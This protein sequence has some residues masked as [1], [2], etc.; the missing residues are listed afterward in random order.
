MKAFLYTKLPGRGWTWTGPSRLWLGEDHVLLVG[1][2]TFYES[3]RRFFFA[4]LQA[5]V[6]QRTHT[7]KIWNGV[8]AS[9]LLFF[10]TL[11]M[12]TDDRTL[13]SVL[14][15]MGAPF[16]IALLVNTLHG[17]TCRCHFRTAV[18]T[19][20]V[21]AL[22]RMRAARQFLARVEP[23]IASAQQELPADQFGAAL[24]EL[25]SRTGATP[26]IVAN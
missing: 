11:T 8:W 13:A 25:Q 4:D 23:L 20:R 10:A 16:G 18:Q 14:L 9:G 12:L 22:S 17:P 6:V 26:P 3:Y 5:I 7:G 15:G 24:A 19:E 21:P 1:S 2:Q